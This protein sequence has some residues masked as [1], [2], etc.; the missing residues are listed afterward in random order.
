MWHNLF[1]N[2]LSVFLKRLF[3]FFKPQACING[4]HYGLKTTG[5]PIL[6]WYGTEL[7][8]IDQ[9]VGKTKFHRLTQVVILIK[10]NGRIIPFSLHAATYI[11][12]YKLNYRI[13]IVRILY[14]NDVPL[15]PIYSFVI[16]ETLEGVKTRIISWIYLV[17]KTYAKSFVN[18]KY[19]IF[20]PEN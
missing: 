1:Y 7:I 5:T 8:G 9:S 12:F 4:F 10:S 15:F 19:F 17:Y 18:T 3:E 11:Y 20:R 14:I 6:N 16:Q 13:E 2:I